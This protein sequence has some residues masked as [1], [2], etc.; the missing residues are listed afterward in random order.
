MEIISIDTALLKAGDCKVRTENWSTGKRP[1]I[2]SFS[3][4][5]HEGEGA[6]WEIGP[7]TDIS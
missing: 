4:L 5:G 7:S 3:R 2:V 6:C 1:E